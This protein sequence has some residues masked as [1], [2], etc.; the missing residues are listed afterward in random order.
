MLT[1]S[2][3]YAAEFIDNRLQFAPFDFATGNS[4]IQRASLHAQ[5]GDKLVGEFRFSSVAD[6]DTAQNAAVEVFDRVLDRLCFLYGFPIRPPRLVAVSLVPTNIPPGHLI[7]SGGIG[8]SVSGSPACIRLNP[9]PTDLLPTIEAASLRGE[10]AFCLFRSALL[11]NGHVEK[12]MHLYNILLMVFNDN[13][14]QVDTF[15]IAQE[16]TVPQT[17][18]PIRAAGTM[19]TVYSRLRNEFAHVRQG[20]DIAR[21]K[22]EMERRWPKLR[23]HTKAGIATLP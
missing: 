9:N 12:F 17:Q 1:G 23:D 13:Q 22:K 6:R 2:V 3:T 18:H 4:T 8:L 11:S 15:I 5:T 14:R 7:A 10:N 20:V 16:P 21:T 19:E